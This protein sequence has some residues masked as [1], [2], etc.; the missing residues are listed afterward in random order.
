MLLVVRV[1]M[2]FAPM[3]IFLPFALMLLGVGAIYSLALALIVHEG[4]PV[5]GIFLM[6]AGLMVGMLG[7]I[8]DQLSQMRL[9]QYETMAPP[10]VPASSRPPAQS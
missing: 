9:A 7:L 8:A 10:R 1:I 4:F 5:L 6:L 2:M 3:R